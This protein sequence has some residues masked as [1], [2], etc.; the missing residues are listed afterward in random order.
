LKIN[1]LENLK[2][3][4]LKISNKIILVF[5]IL[6]GCTYKPKEKRLT[7]FQDNDKK[8][9][10]TLYK[11]GKDT[12]LFKRI[13]GNDA[14]MILQTGKL[15]HNQSYLTEQFIVQVN[16]FAN[17][18]KIIDSLTSYYTQQGLIMKSDADQEVMFVQIIPDSTM[19]N[20]DQLRFL[21]L[22][23]EIEDKIDEAL[24]VRSLGKWFAGDMGVGANML[25][26][27]NDW[28]KASE[29]TLKILKQ[30]NLIDHVLIAKRIVITKDDWNYEI[31]Y[32]IE[33]SG[34]FNEM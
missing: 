32:P 25:F 14:E 22:R 29:T 28:E 12:I 3:G 27:I 24:K 9:I 16:Q 34:V 10:K 6:V 15:Y 5:A 4:D 19:S 18:E 26:F 2:I 31:I 1:Q 7:Q 8:I 21:N 13:I 17:D 11:I 23:Q 33:F 20:L 30:E